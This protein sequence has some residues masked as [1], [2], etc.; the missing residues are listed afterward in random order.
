MGGLGRLVV[1]I[2]MYP[3]DWNRTQEPTRNYNID[4]SYKLPKP[5]RLRM[6]FVASLVGIK[7]NLLGNHKGVIYELQLDKKQ[8]GNPSYR[9]RWSFFRIHIFVYKYIGLFTDSLL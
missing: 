8:R 9:L 6:C 5:C 7:G 2:L 3:G 1:E 4:V